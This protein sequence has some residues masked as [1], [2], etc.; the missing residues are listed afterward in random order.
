VVALIERSDSRKQ[1]G[2]AIERLQALQR[3]NSLIRSTHLFL[4]AGPPVAVPGAALAS[5]AAQRAFV[6]GLTLT[7]QV[8][9]R[10]CG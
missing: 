4:Q 5:S 6:H 9:F 3:A 10:N 8:T 1:I 2:V 7:Q